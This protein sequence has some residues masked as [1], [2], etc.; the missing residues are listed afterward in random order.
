MVESNLL[1]MNS[2]ENISLL[3][4][5]KSVDID[6]S[7][8]NSDSPDIDTIALPLAKLKLQL[9]SS[10]EPNFHSNW[11]LW[12]LNS[13]KSKFWD[14]RL[15]R[16]AYVTNINELLIANERVQGKMSTTSSENLF[17]LRGMTQ[18]T[19]MG[20]INGKFGKYNEQVCGAVLITK[21]NKN[22]IALWTRD[23]SN[24]AAIRSMGVSFKKLL[25]VKDEVEYEKH[26][27]FDSNKTVSPLL[28]I[29][30]LDI[31]NFNCDKVFNLLSPFGDCLKVKFLKPESNTCMVE[32]RSSS[33]TFYVIQNL[34]GLWLYGK[35]V[36]FSS[37]HQPFVHLYPPKKPFILAYFAT[38]LFGAPL[39]VTE[40]H[41]RDIFE[42]HSLEPRKVIFFNK[43]NNSKKGNLMGIIFFYGVDEAIE[44]LITCNHAQFV[45]LQPAPKYP[46]LLKLSFAPRSESEQEEEGQIYD[47]VAGTFY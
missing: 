3:D 36:Q 2:F 22:V 39:N 18:A 16:I 25:K 24:A 47:D 19:A 26:P 45:G 6:Q 17:D 4:R 30:G 21:R 9:S 46:Q 8:N 20:P 37:S 34:T 28:M 15:E 38:L 40:D 41:I 12:H 7:S 44:G 32:M 5:D 11:V 23:A 43:N 31:E 14:D 33:D 42:S 13:D 27:N 35:A 29:Y 1:Q 10:P